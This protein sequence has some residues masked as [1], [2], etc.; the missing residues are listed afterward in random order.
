MEEPCIAIL[1]EEVRF[2][3]SYTSSPPTWVKPLK[4][5]KLKNT[6]RCLRSMGI[7]INAKYEKI[8]CE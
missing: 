8:L 2:K 6:I 1:E 3:K 5:N 4:V 7:K